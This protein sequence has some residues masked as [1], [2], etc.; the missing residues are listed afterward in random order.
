MPDAKKAEEEDNE[1]PFAVDSE[2]APLAASGLPTRSGALIGS[3]KDSSVVLARPAPKSTPT[4]IRSHFSEALLCYVK[5][6]KMLKTSIGAV[7]GVINELDN[8]VV[9]RVSTEQLIQ[10]N[11]LKQRCEVTSGWLSNQF[12]GVLERGDAANVEISKLPSPLSP[13]NS[14]ETGTVTSVEAL[15]YNH[16]LVCGREGAVKQLLGHYEASRTCYR[17]AGLLAETLLMEP[18]IEDDDRKILEAY[19]DGFASQITELDELM[20]QQSQHASR[21]L[22]GAGGS[23]ATSSY[24]GGSRP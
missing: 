10:V 1:M 21:M 11:T 20:S 23:S 13:Q 5:A 14:L 6:L 24:A 16:A 7:E 12:K 17:S 18:R 3:G 22:V 15:I 9:K 19:V 4:L 2:P 8:I